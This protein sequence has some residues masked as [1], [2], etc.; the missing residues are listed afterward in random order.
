[1]PGVQR[2]RYQ[3]AVRAYRQLATALRAQGLP[4]HAARFAFRARTLQRRVLRCERPV[5]IQNS[6]ESWHR[7][8]LF[9]KRQR[10]RLQQIPPRQDAPLTVF[11][12]GDGQIRL[13]IGIPY[14][15]TPSDAD[16]VWLQ[17]TNLA[18]PGLAPAPPATAA[19]L[20]TKRSEKEQ[21]EL[22][23]HLHAK[24]RRRVNAIIAMSAISYLAR[25]PTAGLRFLLSWA[26]SFAL[27]VVSGYGYQLWRSVVTY[28]IV[29]LTFACAYLRL[30]T[31]FC[32]PLNR[33]GALTLSVLSF[34]GRGIYAAT[35][36]P[37]DLLSRIS[38]AEAALGLLLEVVFIATLTQ[39][40]F[41]D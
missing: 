9:A 20:P 6:V 29:V 21:K 32:P 10:H 35:L 7:V 16:E 24:H 13:A 34:H 28:G 23:I 12:S 8:Q 31:S 15:C 4:E 11:A 26:P 41:R 25:W 5:R 40:V 1:M 22:V 19:H 39:R 37:N 2:D 30:G 38:A 27:A 36:S 33:W 18:A 3:L 17:R 14:M